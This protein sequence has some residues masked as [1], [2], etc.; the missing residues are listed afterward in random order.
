M[1]T[2]G[3]GTSRSGNYLRITSPAISCLMLGLFAKKAAASQHYCEQL[4]NGFVLSSYQQKH[5]LCR[6]IPA[7]T[8]ATTNSITIPRGQDQGSVTLNPDGVTLNSSPDSPSMTVSLP[9]QSNLHFVSASATVRD[10]SLQHSLGH[11]ALS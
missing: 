3:L 1:S 4:C 8:T 9:C 2:A 6:I 11:H 7:G 10:E 5:W